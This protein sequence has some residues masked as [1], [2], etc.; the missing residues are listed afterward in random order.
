MGRY[1]DL[2]ARDSDG[3]GRDRRGNVLVLT[4]FMMIC[5]VAMLA[6]AVD[7]GYVYVSSAELQRAADAAAIAAA[8]ELIDTDYGATPNVTNDLPQART[9]AAQFVAHNPVCNKSAEIE[10][11]EGN[12]E[13][14]D[15]VFGYMSDVTN[16]VQP[17]DLASLTQANAVQVRVRRTTDLNGEVPFFFAR[18]LGFNSVANRAEATAAV[19]N[20][21]M[22][23]ETPDDGG[24]LDI[25]PFALDEETWE[26]MLAGG[27]NDQWTRT[28]DKG[29]KVWLVSGG[30]DGVREVNLFPQGIDSSGNRGTVDIGGANNST[31]DISL[32]ILE[33]ISPADLAYHGGELK[34]NSEGKLFLNGDTGI[35]AAFKD[36]LESIIGQPRLIPIFSEVSQ[37]GDNAI[38]TIVKFVGVSILDVKLTGSMASKR[39]TIQPAYCVTK[40]G[41]PTTGTSGTQFIYSQPFLVQ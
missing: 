29:A 41:I 18:A 19:A 32:Q 25:L 5:L 13:D 12:S 11:N 8:W 4:A 9:I 40:G 21:F 35:S 34:F 30:S 23:F 7:L 1:F 38:Y 26:D 14:G 17:L 27:G 37:P 16:P 20:A 28:Y 2:L 6:F 15:I 24:N 22:G 33:G 3:A 10:P 39:V 36:E 31:D